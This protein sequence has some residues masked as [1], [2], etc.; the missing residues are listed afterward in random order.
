M[1]FFFALRV[2]MSDGLIGEIGQG[3]SDGGVLGGEDDGEIVSIDTLPQFL[4]LPNLAIAF[5]EVLFGEDVVELCAFVR[6]DD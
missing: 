3:K 4:L 2:R 1:P 6:R 5:A